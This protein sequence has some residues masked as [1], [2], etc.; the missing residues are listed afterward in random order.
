MAKVGIVWFDKDLRL[1]D[2]PSLLKAADNCDKLIC[3]YCFDPNWLLPNQYGLKSFSANR[4]RFLNQ[5]LL[6][7]DSNLQQIGQ[8]L[9]ICYDS[10]IKILVE[11]INRY[12]V[13]ALYRNRSF[14]YEENWLWN[15][16]Q[17]RVTQVRFELSDVHTLFSQLQLDSVLNNFPKHF[18]QFRHQVE[19]L[20]VATPLASPDKLPHPVSVELENCFDTKTFSKQQKD[21]AGL[22][23]FNGGEGQALVQLQAYFAESLPSDYKNVRDQLDGWNNSTKFSPW[24]SSG[25]LSVR[26][27]YSALKAYEAEKGENESTYWI[28]FE[29]LWREFFQWNAYNHGV[30]I[31]HFKGLKSHPP[32]TCFYPERFQKWCHGNTPYPL[33]NACMH[34]LNSLGFM[35]NRGRQIVASCLVNELGL[36]WRFGAAY[37]EQ[38]LIDYDVAVNW[39]NW[40]YLAGVGADPRGQRHFNLDKQAEL[41]DK[42]G[43]FVKSWHGQTTVH[44]L[45]SVDAADWPVEQ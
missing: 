26:Q 38:Q 1:H 6:E 32:L 40:Q 36:D 28:Y 15:E 11:L 30:K 7:L 34:Q 16:L 33:V 17:K 39:G 45:D 22:R 37:F 43:R 14:G 35:S 2:N 10:P 9:I 3:V 27:L 44:S 21:Q 8:K 13:C 12:Q 31:F 20:P 25:C 41:F 5:S 19:G 4:L 42:D 24:L 23:P 18:N 29:L